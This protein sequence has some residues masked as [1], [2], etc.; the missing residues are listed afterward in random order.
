VSRLRIVGIAGSLALSALALALSRPA[1]A[2]EG[3]TLSLRP[4]GWYA[5]RRY[6]ENRGVEVRLL[7]VTLDAAAPADVLVLVFPFRRDL[8]AA[9]V[10][11]L[12]RRVVDGG[13]VVLALTDDRRQR[14]DRVS[15]QDEALQ[16]LGLTSSALRRKPPLAPALWRAWASEEW[17]LQPE[18]SP[19]GE[20]GA[21]LASAAPLRLPPAPPGARI[22][23]RGPEEQP[24]VFRFARGKGEV[25]VMPADVLSNRRLA[26]ARNLDWLEGLA[27]AH[28]G[29]WSFDEFHHGLARED[30]AAPAGNVRALDMFLLHLSLVYALA[31]ASVAPRF[32]PAWSDPPVRLGST[33]S[34]LLGLAARHH[35]SR[36][37]AP[38]ARAVLRRARELEPRVRIDPEL[39]RLADRGTPDDLLAVARA[40]A[41][42]WS[43]KEKSH[44]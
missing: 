8:L 23:H 15:A 22:L 43:P 20:R 28:R 40:V 31:L 3:S 42:A 18:P 39:E 7:D 12:S 14:Q 2:G 41:R 4:R 27:A 13:L 32:G 25:L 35:A 38:A 6:L 10:D 34:F 21:E 11:A 1:G 17:V 33:A 24:V 16:A 30:A 9:E 19:S 29:A 37:H 5:A 44:V 36:H 26:Q